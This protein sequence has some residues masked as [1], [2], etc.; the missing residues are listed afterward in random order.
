MAE[1]LVI[2]L[3]VAAILLVTDFVFAGGAMTMTG[4]SAMVGLAAHPLGAA[5]LVILIAALAV[6]ILGGPA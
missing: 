5:A 3:I 1:P 6:M 2:V 4:M